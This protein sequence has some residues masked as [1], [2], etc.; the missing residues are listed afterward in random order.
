MSPSSGEDFALNKKLFCMSILC[1][2]LK[3]VNPNLSYK[4]HITSFQVLKFTPKQRSTSFHKS[5]PSRSRKQSSRLPFLPS[6]TV[7]SLSNQARIALEMPSTSAP[8]AVV[9]IWTCCLCID[10]HGNRVSSGM[11]T[12]ITNCPECSHLRCEFCQTQWVK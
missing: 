10:I 6:K 8:K 11:T 2:F 4:H 5:T 3:I 12:Y 1:F 7:T 9:C